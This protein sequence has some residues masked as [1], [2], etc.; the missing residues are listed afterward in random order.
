MGSIQRRQRRR[1]FT[2]IELLVVIAIIGV[3][4]A[5]LLPAVQKVRAAADRIHCAN[6][7]KQLGLALHNYHTANG[8]FPPGQWCPNL[9]NNG[10]TYHYNR[11][12]W[13]QNL[14][15][16]IEQTA[17]FQQID[18]YDR[19]NLN[20]VHYICAAP[21]HQTHVPTFQ[22][23]ADPNGGKDITQWSPTGAGPS[24]GTPQG[25][26]GFHGNY[27]L[28][29][30]STVFNPPLSPDGRRL[31]GIFFVQSRIRISDITDGTSNTL[32]SS[33]INLVPDNLTGGP[34]CEGNDLRGR[35]YN[36]YFGD[37]LFSTLQPPNT[38]LFDVTDL[39]IHL[40]TYAPCTESVS[41][42]EHYARSYHVGGVN[43]GL[44]DGSVRFI[45]NFI[46]PLT[47]L[48]MGSRN[49][50]EVVGDDF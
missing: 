1:A 2:L 42:A 8:T 34:C 6:N 36:S 5:L 29:S 19:A 43:A 7:L 46:N 30:G 12:C 13:F 14:L 24:D 4:I 27:V 3:L 23:P 38:S 11:G 45:S 9:Q 40:P 20:V 22:C 15:P 33:E 48:A 47:Y 16:F 39:C 35:Y 37:T 44:A 10:P 50:G 26:Q 21:G 31:N 25:S 41:S 49:G 17:L 18:A 32:L 28:C